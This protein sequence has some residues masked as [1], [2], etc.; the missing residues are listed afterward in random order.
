MLTKPFYR[1]PEYCATCHSLTVPAAIN[2][3][4]TMPLTDEAGQLHHRHQIAEGEGLPDRCIDCHMPEVPS[5]DP[6]AKA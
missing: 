5:N 4:A 3:V 6:A 2:G 1:S